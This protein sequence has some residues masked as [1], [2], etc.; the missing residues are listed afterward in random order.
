[1]PE[2]SPIDVRRESVRICIERPPQHQVALR[3]EPR[4]QVHS[5]VE[6]RKSVV[7]HHDQRRISGLC[8]HAPY[9]FIDHTISLKQLTIELSP[10][11][12]RILIDREEMEEEE[13]A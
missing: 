3:Q 4:V 11:H 9:E 5:A 2:F 10:K 13:P 1:M 6:P 8:T 7:G 12:V